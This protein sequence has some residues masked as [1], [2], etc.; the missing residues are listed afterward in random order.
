MF[1]F[2]LSTLFTLMIL[3][4]LINVNRLCREKMTTGFC[5]VGEDEDDGFLS[6]EYMGNIR[7]SP[8]FQIFDRDA[9]TVLLRINRCNLDNDDELQSMFLLAKSMGVQHVE[10]VD[11]KSEIAD[12]YIH[13]VGVLIWHCLIHIS[14]SVSVCEKWSELS[15]DCVSLFYRLPKINRCNLD[16]DDELQSM[17]LLAK[18][19]RVQHAEVVVGLM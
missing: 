8:T 12:G 16:S 2:C 7:A 3:I 18:S 1:L 13:V 4:Q 19:M 6:I 15:T 17:F 10:V 14:W 11:L 5:A 9:Y